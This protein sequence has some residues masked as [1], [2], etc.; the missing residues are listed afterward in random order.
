MTMHAA[1]ASALPFGRD[2]IEQTIPDRFE[3]VA[4]TWPEPIPEN[5]W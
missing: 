1:Q 4:R 5:E 2:D 3:A